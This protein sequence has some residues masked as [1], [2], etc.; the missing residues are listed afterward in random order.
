M[1]TQQEIIEQS[2]QAQ[3]TY[4]D[5]VRSRHHQWAYSAEDP[6]IKRMHLEIADLL[7]ET[8]NQYYEL[9]STYQSLTSSQVRSD[10]FTFY[11]VSIPTSTDA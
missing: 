7:Q 5:I 8:M 6:E 9:L 4:L 11:P 3:R 2:M 10:I 1:S